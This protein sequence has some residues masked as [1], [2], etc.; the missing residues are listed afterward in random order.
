MT[1]CP[2]TDEELEREVQYEREFYQAGLARATEE[3]KD[4]IENGRLADLPVGKRIIDRT[5]DTLVENLKEVIVP[6]RGIASTYRALI[7]KLGAETAMMI[8]LRTVLACGNSP[9]LNVR[10]MPNVLSKVGMA[11]ET[12]LLARTFDEVHPYYNA[13]IKDQVKEQC[14]RDVRTIRNKYLTG[15]KDVGIKYQPWTD[16]ER[17]GTAKIVLSCI[18]DVGMFKVVRGTRKNCSYIEL[19][20]EVQAF[21]DKHYDRIR[22]VISY[23]V[24]L[25][26]P[27]P[28]KGMYNGGYMIP[29]LRNRSPMMKLRGMPR[30]LRKWVLDH[31]GC[32][33]DRQVREGITKA[34]EVPYRVNQR[35]LEV[36]RKAFAS[37]KGL[38]GLP[39]HGPQP[40]PPFPFPDG[41]D[42]ETATKE[43]MEK[44]TTWKL[45]M[46]SW[47]TYEN[48]RA[49][50]KAGL[51]GKLRYLNEIKDF[52]RWY[53]PAFIDWRG[54]VYFRSTI[55]PQ[56]AD[57]IKGCI[58]F[59]EGKELGKEGLYWLK[60]HV[61]N[62]CGYDKKSFDLRVQWVDEHWS[63]IKAYLDDP[64][65]V[66]PPEVD[67]AFTLLQAGWDLE[68]ALSLPDPS[69]HISHVPV[70]MDATCSGLQHYSAMLR[71]EVGGYYT[72]LV[73]SDSDEK[74]D[75]YKAVAD[76]AMELLPTVTDDEFL[77]QWW[78]E[79]G[80]P[81]AMAKRPVM[82]YVYSAT[83]RSCIDYVTEE[84]REEG[85]DVP[86]GYSYI[87]LCAPI[88][89][90]LRKAVEATVP[91]A[92]E[93]MD[94]LKAL[95]KS[96]DEAIRWITPV[97]VPVVN[98]KEE[99][100]QKRLVLM[101]MG[102]RSIWYGFQ[103]ADYNRMKAINGISPNFIHSMDSSH[104]IKVVNAFN[105]SVLCIHDSFGT[106]ACDVPA[107]RTELLRQFV[108]LYAHYNASDHFV[109][110]PENRTE[111]Q[112]PPH[113]ELSLDD[114]LESEFAF[115]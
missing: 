96:Q 103:G 5:F 84:M 15:C 45:L 97:G 14:V 86:S 87:S 72:N 26:K 92:K 112:F 54:R 94:A 83:L 3:L 50:K 75:I 9:E 18:W 31:L 95:V 111:I 61:A 21:L 81:R 114:I 1:E 62:C 22:P 34:Q 16:A 23:P 41:W 11:I 53:C 32:D 12:E 33:G 24:M 115:C 36:A 2:Y 79:R 35:V 19:S 66:D 7:R 10:S 80:I 48:T 106:H 29:E 99:Y 28:W 100:I 67:T 102:I 56:S 38:L 42:K 40:E 13:R 63:E 93:G 105:G 101:S 70:A 74:H 104:L 85:I 65:N 71:D 17:L 4:A 90:A 20:E 47:Y 107:L 109:L 88:G 59:A 55:N 58:D 77:I 68:R 39:P 91:K 51:A 6:T 82:T 37:P 30:D 113:G 98:Y 64:L 27:L 43:D 52:D 110:S 78:K 49:G 89:K 69:K 57:V 76:K 46:K 25:V 73:K 8:G 44:F 108:D 60:V